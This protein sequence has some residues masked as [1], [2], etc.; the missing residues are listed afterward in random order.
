M[1]TMQMEGV[2]LCSCDAR[3]DSSR[4]VEKIDRPKSRIPAVRVPSCLA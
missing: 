1:R 3:I 4:A 2:R